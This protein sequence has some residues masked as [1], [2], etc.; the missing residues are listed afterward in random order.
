MTQPRN[1][2]YFEERDLI[3]RE[4]LDALL[5]MLPEYC[6]EYILSLESRGLATSTRLGYIKDLTVFFE[7]LA[8]SCNEMKKI[9]LKDLEGLKKIDFQEFLS[10]QASGRVS[11]SNGKKII[12]K[13][14]LKAQARKL[15]AVKS[16][17][18]FLFDNDMIG[19][20]NS[21]K[22]ESPKISSIDSS[23]K[24]LDTDE[25]NE[26]LD[27]P[28]RGVAN[29]HHDQYLKN[30]LERDRAIISMFLATGIRVS[31]LVGLDLEDVNLNK[32]CFDV[33]RKGGKKERLYM[34][35]DLADILYAWLFKR[36]AMGLPKSQQA[37][38]ISLQRNRMGVS[39]VEKMISK[40]AQAVLGKKLSPHRLR[41]TYGTEL[42]KITKDIYKVA[43]ALGHSSVE[44]TRKH[45]A[46]FDENQK[47]EIAGQVRVGH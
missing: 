47:K 44:T 34:G 20:N 8:G 36:E 37:F 33:Q 5:Y 15:S 38:F 35:Q 17:Y 43:T 40:Y 30:T 10:K 26:F 19:V 41:A 3:N 4:Q 24:R 2:D 6:S 22:V 1:F 45:Y 32:L 39:A 25:K 11:Y 31:E 12:S 14:G 42:Y 7:Y 13:S 16:L 27:A 9:S 18:K 21:T 29:Q 28:D 46:D 23:I